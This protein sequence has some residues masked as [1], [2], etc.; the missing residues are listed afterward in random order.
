MSPFTC[1]PRGYTVQTSGTGWMNAYMP[2]A[3]QRALLLSRAGGGNS[4]SQ[5]KLG[6]PRV[7]VWLTSQGS[8]LHFK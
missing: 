7:F 6:S 1:P 4:D 3:A 2:L 5:A 8:F